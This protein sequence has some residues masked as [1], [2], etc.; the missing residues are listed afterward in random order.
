MQVITFALLKKAAPYLAGV[1]LVLGIG[2]YCGYHIGSYSLA[3]VKLALA[4]Q[5]TNDAKAIATA[6]AAAAAALAKADADANAAEAALGV[7]DKRFSSEDA[8][9]TGQI[10]A[11]APQPGQD[12]PDAP[13]LAHTLD[14]LEKTP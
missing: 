4:I 12:A 13:V 14:L 6:N 1:S 10:S 3:K 11:Q 5:Q 7:A 8:D 9:L 2:L